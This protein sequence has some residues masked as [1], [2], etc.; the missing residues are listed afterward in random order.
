M[1]KK[2][3]YIL[4]DRIGELYGEFPFPAINDNDAK[5]GFIKFL[6]NAEKI[7]PMDFM[8]FRIGIYDRVDGKLIPEKEPVMLMTGMDYKKKGGK[9]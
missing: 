4:Y 6:E 3:V 1:R 2:G 7:R 5:R 8:L 9:V